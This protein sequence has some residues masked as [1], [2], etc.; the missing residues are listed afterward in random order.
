MLDGVPC[1][2]FGRRH[3]KGQVCQ[4]ADFGALDAAGLEG[5]VGADIFGH[6][7]YVDNKKAR[8]Q[9]YEKGCVESSTQNLCQLC[10]ND[11]FMM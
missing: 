11:Q 9:F 8:S 5:M 4:V 2:N 7:I 6:Y 10:Y 3:S 1:S